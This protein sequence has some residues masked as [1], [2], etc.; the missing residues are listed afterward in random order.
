M[1]FLIIWD[2]EI[3]TQIL[4]GG[5]AHNL[6]VGGLPTHKYKTE[7]AVS[8]LTGQQL[9]EFAKLN[10]KAKD[11][12]ISVKM[13]TQEWQKLKELSELNGT[14][15]SQQ[16]RRSFFGQNYHLFKGVAHKPLK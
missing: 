10:K 13:T 3:S 16:M 4:I 12:R 9:F 7:M 15:M 2:T 8:K 6:T 14:P 1:G 11:K 5:K